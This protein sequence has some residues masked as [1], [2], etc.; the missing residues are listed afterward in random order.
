MLLTRLIPP[1]DPLSPEAAAEDL[2]LRGRAPAE[3]PYVVCNMAATVDGHT[4]V[5]GRSRGLSSDADRA[6]F[7]A[8][9]GQVDAILAGTRTIGTEGYRRLIRDPD[10]RAARER[11]GLAPDPLSVV[12]SRSGNLPDIPLL[13]D[14]AQ[15]RIVLTGDDAEPVAA[16]RRVRAEHGVEVLLCEGGGTLNG[17]LL[18][19]GLIDELLLTR[20]PLLATGGDLVP[21]VA[22][23]EAHPLDLELLQLLEREGELF[24][25][26]A[27]KGVHA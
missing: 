4:T 26:Y 12:L 3:R 17:S 7:H 6:W 5:E 14:S 21:I 18:R 24:H 19:A 20:P 13:S 22:A 8:L 11:R 1:G 27:V 9:R 23:H 10:A 16:L 25:R 2:R 15:P